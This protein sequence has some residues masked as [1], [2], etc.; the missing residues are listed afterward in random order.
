[1]GYLGS[2]LE[3]L[4]KISN[5]AEGGC[6][7]RLPARSNETENVS[8]CNATRA[9]WLRSEEL[10]W[11]FWKYFWFNMKEKVRTQLPSDP[12]RWQPNQNSAKPPVALG[13]GQMPWVVVQNR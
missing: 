9:D 8:V 3:L 4:F 7:P 1:M 6:F 11:K 10:T 13:H 12:R 2:A 5:H